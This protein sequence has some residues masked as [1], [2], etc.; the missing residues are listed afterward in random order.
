MPSV[1]PAAIAKR[2]AEQQQVY[3]NRVAG[4]KESSQACQLHIMPTVPE[5]P[6]QV[7]SSVFPAAERAVAVARS[8]GR[9]WP[10][11]A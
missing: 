11:V 5:S 10:G 4:T 3:R 8:Q 7:Q 1:F 6:A 9:L 2:I